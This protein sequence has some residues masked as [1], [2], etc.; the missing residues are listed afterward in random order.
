VHFSLG[1]WFNLTGQQ[2]RVPWRGHSIGQTFQTVYRMRRLC[3][4]NGMRVER[5]VHHP[6]FWVYVRKS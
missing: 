5:V 4:Q 1:A 2:L 6:E 3:A